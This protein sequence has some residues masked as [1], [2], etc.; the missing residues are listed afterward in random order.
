M[1]NETPEALKR[2]IEFVSAYEGMLPTS[3]VD[4]QVLRSLLRREEQGSSK[5]P[6]TKE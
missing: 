3:K 5:V 4:L 2:I 6:P 1:I